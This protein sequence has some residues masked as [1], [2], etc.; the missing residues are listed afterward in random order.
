M[1]TRKGKVTHLTLQ[2]F[3]TIKQLPEPSF[4]TAVK[5]KHT[6]TETVCD[7]RKRV[8]YYIKGKGERLGITVPLFPLKV[9]EE[10]YEITMDYEKETG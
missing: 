7:D 2:D 9:L 8:I 4:E 5:I 1:R 6:A 3:L 10:A